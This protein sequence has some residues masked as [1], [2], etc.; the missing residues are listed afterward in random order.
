VGLLGDIK[1]L[2]WDWRDPIGRFNIL[3]GIWR[4]TPGKL[5]FHWRDTYIP[6]RF[7]RAAHS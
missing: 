7:A 4:L 5:G 6:R 2:L 1:L 3:N